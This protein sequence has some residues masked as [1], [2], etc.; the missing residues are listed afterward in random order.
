M[1]TSA[2]IPESDRV[3]EGTARLP[4]EIVQRK[5]IVERNFK[6]VVNYSHGTAAQFCHGS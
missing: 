6:I 2:R 1:P 3:G 4:A 5:E